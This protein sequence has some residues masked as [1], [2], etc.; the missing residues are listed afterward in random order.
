[1]D[2][3]FF[4]FFQEYLMPSKTNEARLLC[5]YEILCTFLYFGINYRFI[6]KK[7]LVWVAYSFILLFLDSRAAASCFHFNVAT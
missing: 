6:F 4:F 5:V 2:C 1:M 7:I 3:S